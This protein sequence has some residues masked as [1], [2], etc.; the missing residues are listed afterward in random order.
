M[1]TETGLNYAKS[2]ITNAIK[3]GKTVLLWGAIPCTGGSAWQHYNKRCPSA[4]AKIRKHIALFKKIFKNFEELSNLVVK[5]GGVVVNE[6]PKQC[7][8]WGFREVERLFKV[9]MKDSVTIDGCAL[10]LRSIVF[11]EVYQETMDA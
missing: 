7:S 1:S 9:I 8:Y 4:A 11:P 10:N 3:Q 2:A 6:W 5:G